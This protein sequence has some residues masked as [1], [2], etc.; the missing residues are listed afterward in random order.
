[1]ASH[2]ETRVTKELALD[3][4]ARLVSSS[5]MSM[6]AVAFKID[7]WLDYV[8]L[9]EPTIAVRILEVLAILA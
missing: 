9:M 3:T 8:P 5:A 4:L 6:V 2:S 1:M 7:E